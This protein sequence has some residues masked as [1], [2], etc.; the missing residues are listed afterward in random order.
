MSEMHLHSMSSMLCRAEFP[1]E[2]LNVLILVLL[3]YAGVMFAMFVGTVATTLTFASLGL[4][5]V[6]SGAGT[7][8]AAGTWT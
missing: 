6:A 7:T 2:A 5:A 4:V 8:A 3:N 1:T